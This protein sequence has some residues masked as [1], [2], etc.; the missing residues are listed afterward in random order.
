MSRPDP[1]GPAG[2]VAVAG[3]KDRRRRLETLRARLRF[4]AQCRVQSCRGWTNAR[5]ARLGRGRGK[6]FWLSAGEKRR[7]EAPAYRLSKLRLRP[8]QWPAQTA[9]WKSKTCGE[10]EGAAQIEWRSGRARWLRTPVCGIVRPCGV[11]RR[12]R[13]RPTSVGRDADPWDKGREARRR[14]SRL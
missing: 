1:P 9:H 12:V 13:V 4:A 5:T 6:T 2:F 10:G 7:S 3:Q 14:I 11:V 8:T